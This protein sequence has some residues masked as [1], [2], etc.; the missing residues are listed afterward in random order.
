MA[1]SDG[2]DRSDKCSLFTLLAAIIP[3]T[4]SS[5][6]SMVPRMGG[7]L[8]HMQ[9]GMQ[10]C[11]NR[12]ATRSPSPGSNLLRTSHCRTHDEMVCGKWVRQQLPVSISTHNPTLGLLPIHQATTRAVL[13]STQ[14][15]SVHHA[16]VRAISPR[17]FKLPARR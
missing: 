3:R 7:P 12:E 1:V 15:Q 17:V 16:A 9:Y 11:A 2:S 14:P 6:A 5:A 13:P 4:L 10:P 8:W